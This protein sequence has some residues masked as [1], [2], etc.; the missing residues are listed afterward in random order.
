MG[1]LQDDINKLIEKRHELNNRVSNKDYVS[2]VNDLTEK[3]EKARLAISTYRTKKAVAEKERDED[4]KAFYEIGFLL[5]PDMTEEEAKA[6]ATHYG[7]SGEWVAGATDSGE[8]YM[9]DAKGPRHE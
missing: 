5:V 3:L 6:L 2:I 7:A 1:K 9:R 4:R 8:A